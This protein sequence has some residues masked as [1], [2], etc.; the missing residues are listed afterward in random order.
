MAIKII[1]F[2]LWFLDS[3]EKISFENRLKISNSSQ[4]HK[5]YDFL[6]LIMT[7]SLHKK[8][9][10]FYDSVFVTKNL[11]L[12]IVLIGTVLG[13]VYSTF[14]NKY[15]YSYFISMNILRTYLL[16]QLLLFLMYIPFTYFKGDVSWINY[17]KVTK[18]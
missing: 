14:Q 5:F 11:I 1:D 7:F 4:S 10:N 9:L 15:R 16:Y 18:S 6:W 2:R 13:H 3:D 12:V 8:L 17:Y